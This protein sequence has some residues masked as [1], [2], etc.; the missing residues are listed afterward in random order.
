M[1]RSAILDHLREAKQELDQ[2]ICDIADDPEYDIG[3]FRVAMSHLYHH[4]NTAWN[5]RD[6]TDEA[7]LKCAE[8]DF[9]AWRRF[10]NNSE[11]LL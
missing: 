11:L 5:G 10:P 4:L 8:A 1:N 9:D 6:A 2:T 7:H 3:E